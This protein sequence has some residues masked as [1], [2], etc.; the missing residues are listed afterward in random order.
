MKGPIGNGV[1]KT[2]ASLVVE[3]LAT[4]RLGPTGLSS[5]GKN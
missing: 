3:S 1:A 5:R 2:L 4:R